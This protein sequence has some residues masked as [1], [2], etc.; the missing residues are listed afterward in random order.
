[1]SGQTYT[2]PVSVLADVELGMYQSVDVTIEFL[3]KILAGIPTSE[4]AL[5]YFLDAKFKSDAEKQ[6]FRERLKAG[7]LSKEEIKERADCS[8]CRFEPDKDGHLSIWNG[9]LKAMLREGFTTL[10]IPGQI[11]VAG[12]GFKGAAKQQWQHGLVIDP[13]YVPFLVDGKPVKTPAGAVDKVKHLVD[14]MTGAPRSAIGRHDYMD[15]GTQM[16]FSIRWL[17]KSCITV[18][19]AKELLCMAQSDG[20]GASRSQSNG[21]FAVIAFKHNK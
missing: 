10:D 19:H 3:D 6:D 21:R 13:L 5:E 15:R 4:K 7:T 20:L 14:Q 8:T 2:P 12:T 1:M 18:D 16:K 11:K 17:R 9:N